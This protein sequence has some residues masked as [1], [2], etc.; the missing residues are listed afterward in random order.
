LSAYTA[1]EGIKIFRKVKPQI[2]F[3]NFELDDM[4]GLICLKKIKS[5]RGAGKIPVYIYSHRSN[6]AV[7]KKANAY[8]AAGCLDEMNEESGLNRCL[9]K[10]LRDGDSKS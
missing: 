5:I 7:A 10:V 1:T 3:V 4:P 9:F 6:E 2:S 8:G